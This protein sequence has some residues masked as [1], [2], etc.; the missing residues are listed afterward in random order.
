MSFSYAYTTGSNRVQIV[1]DTNAH[2]QK[3]RMSGMMSDP[4]ADFKN[5]P[6]LLQRGKLARFPAQRKGES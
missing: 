3:V 6:V 2:F 5:T 4:D 1:Q